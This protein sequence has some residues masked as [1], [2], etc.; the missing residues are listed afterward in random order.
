MWEAGSLSWSTLDR[1]KE[2]EDDCVK[3]GPPGPPFHYPKALSSK[4][5]TSMNL[6]KDPI[7]RAVHL[8]RFND[9]LI[10]L[11]P[12]VNF[13]YSDRRGVAVIISQFFVLVVVAHVK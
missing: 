2:Q 8:D 1:S 13:I 5:A 9:S 3:G 6:L 4:K 10:P 11:H 7:E 12:E